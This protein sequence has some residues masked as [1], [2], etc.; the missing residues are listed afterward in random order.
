MGAHRPC[1]PVAGRESLNHTDVAWS[2]AAFQKV[3]HRCSC[4]PTEVLQRKGHLPFPPCQIKGGTGKPRDSWLQEGSDLL[5]CFSVLRPCLVAPLKVA[6]MLLHCVTGIT[7]N[8]LLS[9][10]SLKVEFRVS[11]QTAV[12]QTA[13]AMHWLWESSQVEQGQHHYLDRRSSRKDCVLQETL[14]SSNGWLCSWVSS[15]T[16]HLGSAWCMA[17][18]GRRQPCFLK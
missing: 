4:S 11:K 13:G 16:H 12:M 8:F 2:D 5:L 17:G 7:P 6:Q 3:S 15:M 1:S 18:R 10:G 14:L 9:T